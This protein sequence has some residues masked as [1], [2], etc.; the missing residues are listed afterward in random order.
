MLANSAVANLSGTNTG[1][2]TAASI[3]TALGIS[4]LSG[5]NTG[6]QVIPVASSTTPAALGTAAVGTGTTFARAD[7]VHQSPTTVSGNAGTA[8][9]IAGQ[10]TNG[11]LYQ[12][13]SGVTTSTAASTVA[14]QVLTTVTAGGAPTWVTPAGGGA[15]I[16]KAYFYSSF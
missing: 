1:N 14:G 5:S 9:S 8:T 2:E 7:H 12:S 11:V 16:S 4:T 3:K 15:A 13:G 6:D 10:T